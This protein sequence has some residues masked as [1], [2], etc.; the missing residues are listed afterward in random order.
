MDLHGELWPH[1]TIR[2]TDMLIFHEYNT[3]PVFERGNNGQ[4]CAYCTQDFMVLFVCR[5]S[6]AAGNAAGAV[7]TESC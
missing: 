1:F 5:L 6:M 2:K 7:C 4:A 3:H